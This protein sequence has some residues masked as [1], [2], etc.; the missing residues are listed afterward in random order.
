[1]IGSKDS[2]KWYG[3]N[4]IGECFSQD[5]SNHH[6][7]S[8]IIQCLCLGVQGELGGTPRHQPSTPSWCPWRE[9]AGDWSAAT[10]R[11]TSGRRRRGTRVIGPSPR[12]KNIA[13]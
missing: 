11:S 2:F 6:Q 1:M 5:T 13:C 9:G 10:R 4:S 3:G 7:S 12:K 8:S